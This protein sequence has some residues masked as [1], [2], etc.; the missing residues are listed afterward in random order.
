MKRQLKPVRLNG[1]TLIEAVIVLVLLGIAAAV[2]TAMQGGV[3]R[4]LSQGD[5]VQTLSMLQQQCAERVLARR[6]LNGMADAVAFAGTSSNCSFGGKSVTMSVDQSYAG[7]GCPAGFSCAQFIFTGS[8][9]PALI[10]V[11]PDYEL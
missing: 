2:L 4:L 7:A 6:R 5:A 9:I 1:F 10:L 11:L 8:G 3:G